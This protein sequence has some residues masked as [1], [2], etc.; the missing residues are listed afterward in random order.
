MQIYP[1][2]LKKMFEYNLQ[3]G[4]QS[5]CWKKYFFKQGRQSGKYVYKTRMNRA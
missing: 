4:N 3:F 2:L 5:Y 1:V